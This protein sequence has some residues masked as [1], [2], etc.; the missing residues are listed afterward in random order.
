MF[1]VMLFFV[2]EKLLAIWSNHNFKNGHSGRL[3]LLLTYN[4]GIAGYIKF[5]DACP[6]NLNKRKGYSYNSCI[7]TCL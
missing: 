3:I 6:L 1:D 7:E 5:V 2:I 4:N